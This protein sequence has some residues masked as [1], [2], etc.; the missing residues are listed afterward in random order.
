M[1]AND[2]LRMQIFFQRLYGKQN[3]FLKSSEMFCSRN[4]FARQWNNLGKRTWFLVCKGFSLRKASVTMT[5]IV[6]GFVQSTYRE[7]KKFAQLF[8][9][10]WL[11]MKTW[12]NH[13]YPASNTNKNN[14]TTNQ[15]YHN[16]KCSTFDWKTPVHLRSMWIKMT[17]FNCAQLTFHPSSF[18]CLVEPHSNVAHFSNPGRYLLPAPMGETQ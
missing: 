3:M 4:K 11:R 8:L 1:L 7:L 9:C 18:S 15:F 10:V 16:N 14:V 6:T 13:L 12:V 2:L 5:Q 17:H